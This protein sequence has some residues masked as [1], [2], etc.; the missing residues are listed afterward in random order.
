MRQYCQTAL[1]KSPNDID[2]YY[3]RVFLL[4]FQ[5]DHVAY[6]RRVILNRANS[7]QSN[8]DRFTSKLTLA[9]LLPQGFISSTRYIQPDQAPFTRCSDELRMA[10][11]L[12]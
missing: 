10:I 2:A 4:T 6:G 5:L 8:P 12:D 11:Y 1:P 3:W 7:N 9:S